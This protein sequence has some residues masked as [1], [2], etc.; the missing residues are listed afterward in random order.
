MIFNLV[1]GKT[2]VQILNIEND[3]TELIKST[4]FYFTG[5]QLN[6]LVFLFLKKESEEI[7]VFYFDGAL[8]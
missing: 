1:H 3:T 4:P 8:G 2:E 5:S 6:D 7:F